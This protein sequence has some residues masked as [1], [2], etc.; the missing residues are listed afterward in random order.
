MNKKKDRSVTDEERE[1]WRFVTRNDKKLHAE[2]AFDIDCY[3]SEQKEKKIKASPKRLQLDEGIKRQ[4]IPLKKGEFAGVDKRTAERVKKGK[5]PID[6]R[7]D[8]HGYNQIEAFE[9]LQQSTV[10]A[11]ENEK[12]LMLVITGKGREEVGV[13]KK[14]LPLWL[15][16][17]S[18]R[19]IVLAFIEATAKDGGSGAYYVLL[20]RK[21]S[22]D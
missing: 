17:P 19:P 3:A 9:A 15:D 11:Y 8:L 5:M 7:L 1:L 16:A 18:I 22:T 6:V 13:L 10:R 14:S 21:R 12:R 2:E 4:L 20:K